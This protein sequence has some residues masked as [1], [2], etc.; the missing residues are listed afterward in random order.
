MTDRKTYYARLMCE[1][2]EPRTPGK[3]QRS[4]TASIARDVVYVVYADSKAT[5][6]ARRGVRGG[7]PNAMMGMCIQRLFR[8]EMYANG[9]AS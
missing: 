3:Q 4:T 2:K 8:R 1:D 9:T 7:T 6:N 5:L